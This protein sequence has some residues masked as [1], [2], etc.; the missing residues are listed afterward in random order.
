VIH[1]IDLTDSSVTGTIRDTI[2]Q[3]TRGGVVTLSSRTDAAVETITSLDDYDR[4]IIRVLQ[5][6]ARASYQE[7]AAAA[8]ISPSTARRRLERLTETEAL[9]FVAAPNWQKLGLFFI[10]FVAIKVDPQR[11]RSVAHELAAMDEIC[12]LAIA[13]G[14]ADIF[15]QLVLPRNQDFVRFVT[16]RIAPISGIRDI[17]TSMIPEFIKTIEEYRLPLI[18]DR[19]YMRDESGAY[20]IAEKQ[21]DLSPVA[22]NERT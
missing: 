19:L 3:K 15:G 11:L 4:Q 8:G 12:W 16:Q 18:P 7:L 10:A 22:S 17:Q 20:A 13:T 1:R 9:R 6:D 2:S 14:Q 21:I 5:H